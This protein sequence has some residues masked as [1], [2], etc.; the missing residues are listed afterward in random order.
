MKIIRNALVGAALGALILTGCGG[1]TSPE[2]TTQPP[3]ET[4]TPGT[5][6]QT[7]AE[8][9]GDVLGTVEDTIYGPVEVPAPDDGEFTVVALG[10]SDAEVALALGVVPVGV[11]DWMAFGAD[12]KGVGSWAT[13]EFG[14]VDPA[15]FES[16]F[17]GYDYEAIQNLNPDVI[18]NTRSGADEDQ[19]NRLSQ[20][21]PTVYAPEGT[22]DFGTPWDTQISQ[23]A[24]ALGLAEEGDAL[25]A[26]VEQEI[27]AASA[28]HPEFDGVTAV[29]GT[30][31]GDSY[32]AY[33]AGD[34]RWDLLESLGFV[35]NPPVLEL[36]PS[37][38]YVALSAEQIGALDAD[39]A[40]FFP[41]GYSL[42]EMTSD[43]LVGSLQVVQED[44]TVWLEEGAEITQAFS[45]ASPLSI[46]IVLDGLT[47]E[48]AAVV[49]S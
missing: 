25:I 42:E 49:G 38:F 32:G 47:E 33:I 41:I 30:K 12:S 8:P 39:V 44:R 10:W 34:F 13:D 35:Q 23:V 6:T 20:I 31:F 19:Y 4:G 48:L 1:D 45:A 9:G 29:T 17:G 16:P 37:G 14:D 36:E 18:L 27:E 5:E 15:V 2:E 21:A 40:V 28:A 24:A 43:P 26:E 11:S 7:P 46:P 22:P 3:Q